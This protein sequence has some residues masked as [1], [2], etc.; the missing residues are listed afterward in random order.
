VAN[1]AGLGF[2][3]VM[4]RI[5]D[6]TSSYND[7]LLIVAGALILGGVLGLFVGRKRSIEGTAASLPQTKSKLHL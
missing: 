4:G 5:K 7:G 6:A 1:I 2:P 3:P